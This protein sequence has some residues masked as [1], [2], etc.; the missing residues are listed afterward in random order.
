MTSHELS[1]REHVDESALR[2]IVLP[3]D[4]SPVAERALPYAEAL[5]KLLRAPL[6]LVRV[7]DPLHPGL[8]LIHI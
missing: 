8:S 6:H 3:L 5:A 2:R 1:G 7:I 4:G